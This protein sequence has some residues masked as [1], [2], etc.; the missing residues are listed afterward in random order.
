M[1][2]GDDDVVLVNECWRLVTPSKAGCRIVQSH[3]DAF[4]WRQESEPSPL[5][6]LSPLPLASLQ[7]TNKS[8]DGKS[9]R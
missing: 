5:L 4:M 9:V 7:H 6:F 3:T 8:L 2:S 1:H